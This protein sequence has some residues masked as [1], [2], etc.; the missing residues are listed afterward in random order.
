MVYDLRAYWLVYPP[1]LLKT[2]GGRRVEG[3]DRQML[4]E[5]CNPGLCDEVCGSAVCPDWRAND[6][7]QLH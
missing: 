6:V 4:F 5:L 3:K 7:W 2:E 1:N